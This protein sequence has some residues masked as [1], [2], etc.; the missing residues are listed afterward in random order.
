MA[1]GKDGGALQRVWDALVDYYDDQGRD[2]T[3]LYIA[4]RCGL[5]EVFPDGRQISDAEL[6]ES[7][8]YLLKVAPTGLRETIER[9]I[10]QREKVKP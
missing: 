4:H 6:Q 9:A 7:L 1:D 10:T 3:A 8:K 5:Y 2:T